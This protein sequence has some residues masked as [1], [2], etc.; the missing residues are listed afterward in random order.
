M[1]KLGLI[2]VLVMLLVG[3]AGGG[4]S[5]SYVPQPSWGERCD[6][7]WELMDVDAGDESFMVNLILNNVHA[8]DSLG[9]FLEE[10]INDHG[11][12]GWR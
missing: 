9:Y 10:C 11:W 8:P 3:C 1:K 2:L 12:T 5:S 7:A 4:D 6:D